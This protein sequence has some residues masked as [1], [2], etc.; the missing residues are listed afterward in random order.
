MSG[1]IEHLESHL[2][3]IVSGYRGDDTTPDG[4]LVAQF[5]P[6]RPWPGMTTLVTAGLSPH[7]PG[8]E[9]DRPGEGPVFGRGE[10][11]ALVIYEPLMMLESFITGYE[12]DTEI[13]MAWL[14]PITGDEAELVRQEG[15]AAL[16]DLFRET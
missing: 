14:V 12:G 4:V 15:A 6:D 7:P 11:T 1:L 3:E 16:F 10:L 5:A 8:R 13:M 2:G 9:G